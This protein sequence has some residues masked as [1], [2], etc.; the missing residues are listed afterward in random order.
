MIQT[1]FDVELNAFIVE[2]PAFVTL[3]S[4][5]DWGKVFISE[6]Q[7]HGYGAALVIDTNQHNFES[8]ECLMWL[9]MFL[10]GEPLVRSNVTRAAFVQPSEYRR[11]EVVSGV[12]GY[13]SSMDEACRWLQ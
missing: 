7:N 1:R 12:E 6:L 8:V 4:L 10:V 5:H 9:R 2:F 11:P 13:F 3:E